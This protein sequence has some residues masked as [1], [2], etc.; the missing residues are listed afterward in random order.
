M[1]LLL[2]GNLSFR[3]SKPFLEMERQAF[4]PACE[5]STLAVFEL[6]FNRLWQR[7]CLWEGLISLGGNKTV[8]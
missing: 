4:I 2:N 3:V 6:V 5:V 8:P 7:R 1:F